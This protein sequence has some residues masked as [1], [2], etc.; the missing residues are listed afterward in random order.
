MALALSLAP[1]KAHRWSHSILQFLATWEIPHIA[2]EALAGR[3]SFAQKSAFGRFARSMLET[4]YMELYASLDCPRL[5]PSLL[6]N[7]SWWAATIS[8]INPRITVFYR[9]NPDW[10]LYTDA[11]Y[12]EGPLWGDGRIYLLPRGYTD[13]I[14]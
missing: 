11:S 13:W 12:E 5:A 1:G 8:S 4:L 14:R 2:P 7:L 10:V 9:V 6:R 3:L